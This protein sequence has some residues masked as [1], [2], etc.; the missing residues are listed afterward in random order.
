MGDRREPADVDATFTAED[1]EQIL[2]DFLAKKG[3][4][5]AP[6]VRAF[7][8]VWANG[9]PVAHCRVT[10]A[11]PHVVRFPGPDRRKR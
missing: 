11:P 7:R 10:E 2:A 6:Y 4:V 5:R 8:W 9:K 1:M 3:G